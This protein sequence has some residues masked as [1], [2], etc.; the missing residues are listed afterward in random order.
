MHLIFRNKPM[1]LFTLILL[2]T[3]HCKSGVKS[4]AKVPSEAFKNIS[5]AA[6]DTTLI[7]SINQPP[8]N[9]I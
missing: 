6:P 8:I 2:F 9:N 1:Y 4:D 3:T 7:S 5:F